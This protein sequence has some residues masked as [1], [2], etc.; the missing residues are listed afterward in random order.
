MSKYKAGEA[1]TS[2]DQLMKCELVVLVHGK[3][4]KVYHR[5]WF[6]NWQTW[7]AYSLVRNGAL[8][9]AVMDPTGGV[10]GYSSRLTWVDEAA[11]VAAIWSKRCEQGA[12]TTA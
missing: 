6:S 1:I 10:G 12:D 5:G 9:E 4:S 11:T 7:R 8:F 2:L 3:W